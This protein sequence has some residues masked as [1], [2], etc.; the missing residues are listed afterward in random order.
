MLIL[1]QGNSEYCA[2]SDNSCIFIR[3]LW[4]VHAVEANTRPPIFLSLSLYPL[5][6]DFDIPK[7]II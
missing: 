2:R 5:F 7:Q 4:A 1:T 3:V 6:I